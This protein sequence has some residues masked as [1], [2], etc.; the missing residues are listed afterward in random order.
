M[1]I[2]GPQ[3]LEIAWRVALVLAA[4]SA[5]TLVCIL[6]VRLQTQ[7]AIRRATCFRRKAEPLVTAFITGRA[8]E[9][10]AA[11][12]LRSDPEAA[13]ALLMEIAER[14]DPPARSRLDPLFASL[15][16]APREIAALKSGKWE[17]RLQAAERL[18]Y[19]GGPEA[20]RVLTAALGDDIFAVR[21]AAARSLA[22][23][24]DPVHVRPVLE[25]FDVPGEMN[26]RRVAEVLY[27]FGPRATAPLLAV[28]ENRD[29][30]FSNIVVGVAV[31]V[32]GMLRAPEAVAPLTALLGSPEYRVRLNAVRAL[33]QIGDRAA[34][35]GT[36]ALCDDPAWEVRNMAVQALGKLRGVEHIPALV[37]ALG[38]PAWW[39]RFSAGQALRALGAPGIDALRAAMTT[40]SDRFAA[41]M[42]RQLLQE[43]RIVKTKEE[44]P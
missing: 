28:A 12:A 37:K 18:G 6:L 43:Q 41:E 15:D 31:R 11:S 42:S 24:G 22:M 19:I 26:Q 39:V 4:M 35:A 34:L 17:I 32:L 44:R 8:T 5:V 10:D 30:I 40:S 20:I 13:L 29:D 14:L 3:V 38:D 27:D 9:A 21:F 16:F 23:L 36:V 1:E 2:L 33:G 25:A 7:T